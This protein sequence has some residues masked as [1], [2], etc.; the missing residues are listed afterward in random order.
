MAFRHVLKRDVHVELAGD[1][2]RGEQV[3]GLVRVGLQGDFAPQHGHQ[4]V[5]LHVEGGGLGGVVLGRVELVH[6]LARLE[7][8]LAQ[9]R[10]GGHAAAVALLAIAPLRILAEGALHGGLCL[11][12][13]LLHAHTHRLDGREGA[14]QHVRA[15]RADAH[16]GHAGVPRLGQRTVA[17]LDAVD[18]AQLRRGVVAVFVV[19]LALEAD[20][21]S[22]QADMAVRLDKAGIDVF[23][24]GVVDLRAGRVDF[25]GDLHDLP[26]LDE[27]IADKRLGIDRRVNESAAN[28]K[29]VQFLLVV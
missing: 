28:E 4:R 22:V 24:R 25:R 27:D 12:D 3:V 14:A 26:V 20:A 2:Q 7:E 9:V 10:G 15:A 6:V 11:D 1:A 16:R 5:Q 13:H 19:V 21:V 23:A 18:G 8:H 29:H 17:R